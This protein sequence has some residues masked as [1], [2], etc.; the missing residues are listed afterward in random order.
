[1]I[2]GALDISELT[3]RDALRLLQHL[4]YP[5]SASVEDL[6]NQQQ[7]QGAEVVFVSCLQPFAVESKAGGLW[8][9]LAKATGNKISW[10][11]IQKHPDERLVWNH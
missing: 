7:T 2:K 6:S 11:K 1:M 8:G 5:L 3:L 10:R 4:R 9:C